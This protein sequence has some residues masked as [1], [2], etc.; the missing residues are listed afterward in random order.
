M[1]LDNPSRHNGYVITG[2]AYE[3]APGCWQSQLLVEREGFVPEG[4]G[5]SPI[6]VGARA[7]EQQA[8]LAGRRMVDGAG[9]AL[10]AASGPA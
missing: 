7:A 6:C 4:M 3:L 2:H 5:I 9:F 8:L 1:F 10:L